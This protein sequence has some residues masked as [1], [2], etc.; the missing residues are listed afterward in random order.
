[1]KNCSNKSAKYVFSRSYSIKNYDL[2]MMFMNLKLLGRK[3]IF[4]FL[5]FYGVCQGF[6]LTKRNYYF[7]VTFD[8]F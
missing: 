2:S 4:F 5:Y 7:K 1:M 3:F 8:N 6:R